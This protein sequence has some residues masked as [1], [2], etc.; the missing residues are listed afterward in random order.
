MKNV[1]NKL[2]KIEVNDISNS[3]DQKRKYSSPKRKIFN[4]KNIGDLQYKKFSKT[5]KKQINNNLITLNELDNNNNNKPVVLFTQKEENRNKKHNRGI[6]ISTSQNFSPNKRNNLQFKLSKSHSKKKDKLIPLVK[7]KSQDN[8][9]SNKKNLL[10]K[11]NKNSVKNS[12]QKNNVNVNDSGNNT[13]TLISIFKKD[14]PNCKKVRSVNNKKLN[15]YDN[16]SYIINQKKNT[17][18]GTIIDSTKKRNINKKNLLNLNNY[19]NY[20]IKISKNHDLSTK[21]K[22]RVNNCFI[23]NEINKEFFKSYII[24]KYSASFVKNPKII[25][26]DLRK[27]NIKLY[28]EK[29]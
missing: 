16:N 20:S 29:R 12:N 18:K 26:D 21:K 25:N 15:N 13:N 4:Q 1:G 27:S 14:I 24:N 8:D 2:K 6:F 10:T 28:N 5:L 11:E 19:D 7:L 22:K 9:H 23:Y 3:K 17:L